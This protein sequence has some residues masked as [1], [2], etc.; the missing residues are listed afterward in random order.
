MQYSILLKSNP[1]PPL[2]TFPGKTSRLR[3]NH[4][5]RIQAQLPIDTQLTNGYNRQNL[6]PTTRLRAR[7]SHRTAATPLGGSLEG[8]GQALVA[9]EVSRVGVLS[10]EQGEDV[11]DGAGPEAYVVEEH[12]RQPTGFSL[13]FLLKWKKGKGKGKRGRKVNIPYHQA[14]RYKSASRPQQRIRWRRHHRRAST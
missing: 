9:G 14:S 4:A 1:P 12:I 6:Q 11:L 10:V 3:G 8:D 7:A 2:Q 13:H 5:R